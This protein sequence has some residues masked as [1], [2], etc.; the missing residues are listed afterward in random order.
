MAQIYFTRHG[1]TVWN[2]ENKIC[3]ATDIELTERGHKQA[4]ALG[5]EILR[6]GIRIDEI[7]YDKKVSWKA[8][9]FHDVE[10]EANAVTYFICEW[11]SVYTLGTLI[12][13]F[14]KVVSLELDAVDFL[15]AAK[16]LYFFPPLFLR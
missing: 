9:R 13:Q 14:C 5:E 8:H 11:R 15:K 1:E 12:S 2:V 16:F 3:G 10:F 6:Q 4:V 7:L